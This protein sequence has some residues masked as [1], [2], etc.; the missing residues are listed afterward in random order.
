MRVSLRQ[1]RCLALHLLGHGCGG[2]LTVR[3]NLAGVFP[4]P[5]RKFVVSLPS[6]CTSSS[7]RPGLWPLGIFALG[8]AA[9]SALLSLA[10][11]A[12]TFH[13]FVRDRHRF[14]LFL[15]FLALLQL[16]EK[17]VIELNVGCRIAFSEAVGRS[18]NRG[19]NL[20]IFRHGCL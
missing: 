13:G 20:V 19:N 14:C 1:S 2:R 3:Q 16:R 18:K 7:R 15:F 17:F 12:R 6:P 11:L 8:L 10:R 5:A 4:R 9:R